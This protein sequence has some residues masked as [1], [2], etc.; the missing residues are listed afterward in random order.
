MKKKQ[1]TAC[2]LSLFAI[3]GL[4]NISISAN[5]KKSGLHMGR[6]TNYAQDENA[7]ASGRLSASNE[8][9]VARVNEILPEQ[10]DLRKLGLVSS[11]KNQKSTGMCWSFS[12]MCTIETGLIA[13]QPLIDLSEWHLGYYTYSEKFGFPLRT[14]TDSDDVFRQ[15]GNFYMLTPMLTGWLGPVSENLFPFED[16]SVLDPEID[17]QEWKSHAEYHVSD[18]NMFTYHVEEDVFPE[19]IQAVKEAVFQGHT[20]SMSYYNKTA[21]YHSENNAYYFDE[22]EKADGIYHAV[23][24]VGWDDNYPAENF[25]TNPGMNGAWLVK[26][27]WGASWGKDY[28]YFW[29]SYADPSMTEVYYL[30]T[31]PLQKHDNMYQYDDYGYW[32]AFSVGEADNSS[33]VA[34]VF[35]AEKDTYLTSVMLCN[36]MPDEDYS[37][38]IYNNLNEPENPISGIASVE[39]VG[40][41]HT[42]GYHTIDLAQPVALQAGE[43]F[44]IVVKFSGELGQHITCEA[45]TRN[46]VTMPNG[47][48]TSDENMLTEEMIRRDFHAGESYYSANGKR[49]HDIYEEE[50]IND[51]YELEDGTQIETYAMLGNICLRGLTQDA[52]V[53]IFSEESNALPVGTEIYLTSPE[54][55]EIY[56]SINHSEDMLYTSPIVMPDENITISAYV[57]ANNQKYSVYEKEYQIQEAMISSLLSVDNK[58]ISY[59]QFEACDNHEYI[60]TW[61]PDKNTDIIKLLPMTTGQITCEEQELNS[62]VAIEFENWQEKDKLVLHV[63]QEGMQE[64]S[65]MIYLHN[66]AL[67]DVNADG[68]IDAEDATAILIYSAEFGAGEVVQ[69]STDWL[70]RANYNQDGEIDAEDA[71][72]I[73]IYSANEGAGLLKT[74]IY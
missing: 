31:E 16:E 58:N 59:L 8:T 23:T 64:T 12:A 40:A 49:W 22:G 6:F 42:A 56:Y 27:S 18:A 13:R 51:V 34:N 3:S 50:I 65:Y 21:C 10:F 26:N 36:A 61:I 46:T 66:F 72:E 45:Y 44:S 9:S 11:V 7:T 70:N 71:T 38:Q 43:K 19:Q 37:I 2:M 35:T 20:V 68:I 69:R 29:V 54:N 52:G 53:V 5:A 48:I 67:G 24:L 55:G 33:Y 15:G 28:G 14:N 47:E 62:G 1:L 63:S 73:L 74:K 17:W 41:L 4:Q 30:E 25:N 32:T 57:I 39:T 60:T